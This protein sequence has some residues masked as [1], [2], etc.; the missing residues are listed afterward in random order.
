MAEIRTCYWKKHAALLIVSLCGF[1]S[2]AEAVS[3]ASVKAM[4]M[5][6]ACVAYGQDAITGYFNPATAIQV[7][8]RVDLGLYFQIPKR[9][10]GL[11][12]R[13]PATAQS[14][15]FK[16]THVTDAYGDIGL[17]YRFGCCC[18][19]AFGAQWNNYDHIHN[20]F[21]NELTDYSA[22]SGAKTKFNYRTEVL[23]GTLAY[24]LDERHTIGLSVNTYF[25]WLDVTGLD[26]IATPTLS[27]DPPAVTNQHVDHATGLGMTVGWLGNFFCDRLVVGFAYSP[28]VIMGDF[29][30]YRGL[31]ATKA[32]DIPET[33]R[34]GAAVSFDECTVMAADAELRRYSR[35]RSL[36]NQFPGPGPVFPGLFGTPEGPGF[37][38]SDQ[39][40]AKVGLQ[41]EY[42]YGLTARIGYR[43]EQSPIP[44]NGGTDTSLNALTL[45][46][47]E[48]Y[49]TGG[50]TW[51][52]DPWSELS[53]FGEYGFLGQIR[54]QSP[55]IGT[56]GN[57]WPGGNQR[58]NGSAVSLGLAYGYN[59]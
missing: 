36:S 4:G 7:A 59:Y 16:T 49:V 52:L 55:A 33:V 21:R 18:E 54:S 24:E 32:I 53:A 9:T 34:F 38:W 47:T 1:V 12:D 46:T 31:L 35:V 56:A 22:G 6:G 45:R 8:D 30:N 37:G 25:S 42:A 20:H 15:N 28:R 44:R 51:A 14:G 10:L 19:W 48:H 23:T 27:A 17:N 41:R 2:Q 13:V 57:G 40:V 26:R 3:Y 5:G 58:F 29:L 43:Y 39:W 11:T 50:F